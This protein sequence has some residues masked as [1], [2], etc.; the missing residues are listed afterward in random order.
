[1]MQQFHLANPERAEL[2]VRVE[3]KPV[4]RVVDEN[5]QGLHPGIGSS[6]RRV[7]GSCSTKG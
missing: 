2:V 7:V 1:M 5:R 4:Q 6:R 3:P